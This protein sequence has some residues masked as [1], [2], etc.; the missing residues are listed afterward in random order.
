MQVQ[1]LT[2]IRCPLGC[3]LEAVVENGEVT[4]VSGNT[5]PRGEEYARKEITNPTRVVTSSVIV[6]G[7]DYPLVS[8]RTAE[9]IP[10]GKIFD[11]LEILKSV[12]VNAPVR[13]GDV[14]VRDVVGTGVDFIATREVGV[15]AKG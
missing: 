10:K 2:C 12:R 7:G 5:C 3:Q 11:C 9:D 1:T 15:M 6:T 13:T 14:L 8:G 4:K